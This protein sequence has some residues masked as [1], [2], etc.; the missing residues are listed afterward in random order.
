M[1]FDLCFLL[2]H[3]VS[4]SVKLSNE[5]KPWTRTT[6]KWFILIPA[7]I[8]LH[9]RI[10]LMSPAGYRYLKSWC[11]IMKG[12]CVSLTC[13]AEIMRREDVYRDAEHE[14]HSVKSNVLCRERITVRIKFE[15]RFFII[16]VSN[17]AENDKFIILVVNKRKK[18][19]H[20]WSKILRELMLSW[21]WDWFKWNVMFQFHR[22]FKYISFFL[23]L[24]DSTL[25]DLIMCSY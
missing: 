16:L 15:P 8:F 19:Q 17:Q 25:P 21:W 20:I 23:F 3:F 14:P 4:V 6:L 24:F 10:V 18:L 1:E 5:T 22:Y 9:V 2:F 7:N 13:A 11:W 12:T